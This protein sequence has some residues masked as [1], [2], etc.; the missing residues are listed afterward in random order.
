MPRDLPV[1]NGNLL[2][3]FDTDYNIRDICYPYI[4]LENHAGG[5]VSRTGIWGGIPLQVKNKFTGLLSY[6]TEGW[7]RMAGSMSDITS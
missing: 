4:G 2:I 7:G 5:C 6:E 1:G 3:N